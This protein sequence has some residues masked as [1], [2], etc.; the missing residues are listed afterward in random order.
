VLDVQTVDT[1]DIDQ[2]GCAFSPVAGNFSGVTNWIE[3]NTTEIDLIKR[4]NTGL[5]GFSIAEKLKYACPSYIG[6]VWQ[7]MTP[8]PLAPPWR[9]WNIVIGSR[10]PYGSDWNVVKVLGKSSNGYFYIEG[11]PAG[12]DLSMY[13]K[14][15]HPWL[16]HRINVSDPNRVYSTDTPKGKMYLPIFSPVGRRHATGD[17]IATGIWIKP[18]YLYSKITEAPPMEVPFDVKVTGVPSLLGP[19]PLNIRESASLHNLGGVGFVHVNSIWQILEL[20]SNADGVFG[21]INRDWWIT[22]YNKLKNQYYT[23]WRPPT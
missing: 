7:Y 3:L 5:D 21:R 1:D 16:F 4:V 13:S 20:Q 12:A 10:V 17:I 18:E 15:T 23:N 19:K 22:L 9:A 11:I 2:M 6:A 14:E 8:T